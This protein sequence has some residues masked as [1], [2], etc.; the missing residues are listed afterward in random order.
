M[1]EP[2]AAP[3]ARPPRFG[4][5]ASA[6]V[7][8]GGGARWQHGFAFQPEGCGAGGR[9]TVD[10][11]GTSDVLDSTPGPGN[12]DG[13]PFAV[14]ASDECSTFGFESRDWQGRARRQLAAIESYE[15]ANELWTGDLNLP[16]VVSLADPTADTLTAAGQPKG[17][18]DA[19]GL[20]E[21]GLAQCNKGRQGMVHV[22]PLLLTHLVTNDSVRLD[23]TTYI[24]PNGHIVVPDAGYPG[25][26]P[27]GEAAG[28]TQWAYATSF[29]QVMLGP[30]D[31]IP[32]SMTDA[33][34]L[35]QSMDRAVNS[36][37]VYAE[38]LAAWQWDHCC[39]VAVQVDLPM[40]L[41]GGAS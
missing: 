10:C 40:P 7:G 13:E 28:A 20:L 6:P 32:A 4:L 1:P 34:Q 2:I 26:G 23:G 14:W 36:I 21:Q 11:A 37:V 27:N 41:V 33:R 31:V 18:V 16:G 22:T 25:T 30:V 8:D 35:A 24:T 39:H 9:V 3:P 12:E 5:I 15:I 38:R 19:L 29:V 17:A